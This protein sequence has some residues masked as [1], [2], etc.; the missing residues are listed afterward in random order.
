MKTT[1]VTADAHDTSEAA[2]AP[3]APT[4]EDMRALLSDLRHSIRTQRHLIDKS[5]ALLDRT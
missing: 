4:L 1:I 2:S 5:R 3:D